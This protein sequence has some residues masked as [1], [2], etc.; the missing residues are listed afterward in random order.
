MLNTGS[1]S[2]KYE[3]IDLD[4]GAR[5]VGVV[6]EVTDQE[7]AIS[8]VIDELGAASVD[9][10]G[11]RVVH[12]GTSFTAP[13]LLDEA[14]VAELRRLVPLAPLHLPAN[15]AAIDAAR[16]R[17]PDVPH[18]AVFDTAF[19]RTVPAAAHRYAVP[20]AWYEEHGVR[21]YGFHGTSVAYVSAR[22]AEVLARPL[23]DLDLIVAHLGNG[24]SITAV[25][26]GASIDTSMGLSPLE[27]LVMGTRSGD[28]DPTVLG[29]VAAATGRPIDDVL[30]ELST[31]SGLLGLCGASDMR[32]VTE[33]AGDGDDDAALAMD[34]VV[35]RLRRYVGA[36]LAVLGRCDALVFT[37]GI[38]EHS[39]VIRR[40]VC[41]GLEGLG[42][43]VDGDRNRR[44][45]PII[46]PDTSPTA[47]LVVPTDE[48]AEIAGQAAAL[49]AAHSPPPP[50]DQP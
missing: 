4:G 7:A 48:A 8:T 1:S 17:W 36:F 10:V 15:L 47:V 38:G 16:R 30:E 25:H 18:V 31:A 44:A 27:G 43:A 14:A 28:V 41:A 32:V 2:L 35:H 37:A 46:S 33:R 20:R 23:G 34:V 21:R 42:I 3:L 6:D 39:A 50:G 19:H 11:H 40:R 24:A 13:T 22:A 12:G 29:H 49:L 5:R 26:H 45:E 9:V